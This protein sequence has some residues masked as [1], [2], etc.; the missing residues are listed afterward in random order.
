MLCSILK[1]IKVRQDCSFARNV[2]YTTTH[3]T[4]VMLLGAEL[5]Y[6]ITDL[7]IDTTIME[8]AN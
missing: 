4:L 8:L 7:K 3:S 1:Q 2:Y 5:R 6:L